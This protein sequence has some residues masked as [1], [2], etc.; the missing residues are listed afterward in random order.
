MALKKKK[1]LMWSWAYG[2]SSV[3][4][5]RGVAL[6]EILHMIVF[7][8]ALPRFSALFCPNLGGQLPSP[9]PPPPASYA[10]VCGLVFLEKK[11]LV[12]SG[13]SGLPLTGMFLPS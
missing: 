11:S 8:L 13:G 12:V 3:K 5:G 2:D 1:I 10:Y 9:P 4:G 7:L 6:P